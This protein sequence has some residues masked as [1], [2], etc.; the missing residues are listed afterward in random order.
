MK[1]LSERIL[2]FRAKKNISAK[3]FAEMCHLTAQ[4][5][6]NIENNLQNPSKITKLKIEKVLK[7]E[8]KNET[9]CF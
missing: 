2:D 1:M 6:Y 9:V 5:I 8:E 4:T 3:T 7:E